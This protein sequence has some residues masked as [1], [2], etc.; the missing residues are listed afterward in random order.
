VTEE[1]WSWW[2]AGSVHR[3]PWP[4]PV[5]AA[6]PAPLRLAAEVLGA[7]RRAKSAAQASMRAEVTRIEVA[8]PVAELE[9]VRADLTAAGNVRDWSIVEAEELSATVTL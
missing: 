9:R 8:G 1:V 2:Q 4:E 5:L 6:D 3:A 7:I